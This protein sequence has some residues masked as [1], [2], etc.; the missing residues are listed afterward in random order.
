MS[1]TAPV[2]LAETVRYCADIGMWALDRPIS[3]A[4]RGND[5]A[6]LAQALS[7]KRTQTRRARLMTRGEAFRDY[8]DVARVARIAAATPGTVWWVP[9]RAW[10]SPVL[11]LY[12]VTTL[13]NAKN[14]RILWSMDPSNAPEDW[15]MAKREGASTMFFGDDGL[16]VTPNGDRMFR[17]PKTWKH[18]AGHCAICK[19]GCFSTRRVDV[20]L[21]Q[22]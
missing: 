19:A 5:A 21:K 16:A 4:W 7:R 2:T 9:T 1:Q 15:A 6:G 18:K 20:H 13:G 11:W 3:A 8:G 12:I 14:I 10:R 22:H 17:C